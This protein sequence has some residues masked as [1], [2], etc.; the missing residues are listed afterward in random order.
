MRKMFEEESSVLTPREHKAVSHFL[1]IYREGLFTS[2][3]AKV[4]ADEHTQSQL[5]EL[6]RFFKGEVAELTLADSKPGDGILMMPGL[7]EKLNQSHHSVDKR[8]YV[9][10][11]KRLNELDALVRSFDAAPS[12]H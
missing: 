12:P 5:K 9:Q 2:L 1:K 4:D 6:A 11:E 7:I 8:I 10:L 3:Q